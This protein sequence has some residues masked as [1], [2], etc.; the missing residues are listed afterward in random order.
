[1]SRTE[2]EQRE[3]VMMRCLRHDSW[4]FVAE[5]PAAG[6]ERMMVVELRYQDLTRSTNFYSV[7]GPSQRWF[8]R[9]VETQPALQAICQKPL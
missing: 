6:G 5:T 9:V 1:M 3:V 8:V 2:W 7:Q 4:R